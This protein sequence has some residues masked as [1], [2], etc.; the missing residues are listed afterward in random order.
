MATRGLIARK[1]ATGLQGRYHHWDSYPSGLGQTLYTLYHG[2][3]QGDL[4]KMLAVL[5]DEHEAGWSNINDADFSLTPGFATFLFQE[6]Y[7]EPIAP[8]GQSDEEYMTA[9]AA[10]HVAVDA[11]WNRHA[12]ALQAFDTSEAA[13]RPQCYCHGE[14]HEKPQL[15]ASLREATEW[16]AQYAYVIDEVNRRMHVWEYDNKRWRE[17]AQVALD[18]P[19]PDW[20]NLDLR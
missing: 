19:A 11:Y 17:L 7:P 2:H 12:E 13:R 6:S 20:K 18:E 9:M 14:R 4:E 3:F 15:F 8:G 5:I 1:T 16:R 10:Y